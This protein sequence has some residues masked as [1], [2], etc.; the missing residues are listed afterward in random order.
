M[1]K[2]PN[3]HL[4]TRI[5]PLTLRGLFFLVL[6]LA[7]LLLGIFRADLAS[8]FWGTS[9]LSLC[10]YAL[11]GNHFFRALSRRHFI[12]NPAACNLSLPVKGIFPGNKVVCDI[13]VEYLSFFIPGFS[14]R[15]RV[16]LCWPDRPVFS[17]NACLKP[18]P[19]TIAIPFMPEHRGVYRCQAICFEFVDLLGFT[20]SETS[21]SAEEYIRVYP[22]NIPADE[23]RYKVAGENSDNILKTKR[24]SDE[25]L[26][27]KKYFPGDDLRKLNWKIFAHLGELFVRKGE[28]SPPPESR[29]FFMLDPSVPAFM[30]ALNTP[31]YLDSLVEIYSAM[32]LMF[33]INGIQV[34][35]SILGRESTFLFSK[36][37]TADFLALMS[38]IRWIKD[39]KTIP[40]PPNRKMHTVVFSFPGSRMLP[41]VLKAIPNSREKATVFFRE[42]VIPVRRKSG[43]NLRQLFFVPPNAENRIV[44]SPQEEKKYKRLLVSEMATYRNA[45]W[46]LNNVKTI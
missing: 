10:V 25:L 6:S 5:L 23:I 9:F 15:V 36:S 19:N 13:T 14:A 1:D 12:S 28:E 4:L 30:P 34:H 27:V 43:I 2:K 40:L 16:D 8:L 26:E 31:D 7:I 3:R 44:Y 21:L 22:R 42:Y 33:L 39:C 18:G 35:T 41:R 38:E 46:S 24:V 11:I 32:T 17:L 20:H 37:Q 45:P 29:L